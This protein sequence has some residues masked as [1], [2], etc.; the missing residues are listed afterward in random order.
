MRNSGK[1]CIGSGRFEM[2]NTLRPGENVLCG[3]LQGSYS[4]ENALRCVTPYVLDGSSAG[5]VESWGG[6]LSCE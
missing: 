3:G 6:W 4:R 5:N 1:W 2:R